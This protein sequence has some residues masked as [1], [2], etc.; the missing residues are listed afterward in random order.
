MWPLSI[1]T[2][3]GDDNPFKTLQ[4]HI[5]KMVQ[6][7]FQLLF[8]EKS[9]NCWHGEYMFLVMFKKFEHQFDILNLPSLTSRMTFVL[10]KHDYMLYMFNNP[11]YKTSILTLSIG[12]AKQKHSSLKRNHMFFL[13]DIL[14]TW[15]SYGECN[16][17]TLFNHLLSIYLFIF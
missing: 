2:E 5:A 10:R 11:F 12:R 3:M 7:T 16:R 1:S 8:C 6:T 4:A 15:F 9:P 17:K 13:Y 14:K